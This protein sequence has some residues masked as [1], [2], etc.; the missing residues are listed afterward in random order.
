MV[1]LCASP[2]T[3]GPGTAPGSLGSPWPRASLWM[4]QCG[5]GQDRPLP[6]CPPRTPTDALESFAGAG[7]EL[8]PVGCESNTIASERRA[9]DSS[10]HA[11][12]V[13]NDRKELKRRRK[14]E[15]GRGEGSGSTAE[16]K[17]S[18]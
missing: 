18:R 5:Q 1:S 11:A 17:A 3:A 14:K 4:G 16:C 15:R 8:Q 2:G 9:A 10:A 12:P 6:A 13:I 7:G